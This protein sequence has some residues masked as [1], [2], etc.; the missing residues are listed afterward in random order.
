MRLQEKQ[1]YDQFVSDLEAEARAEV[2]RTRFKETSHS[3]ERN[4]NHETRKSSISNNK[5]ELND[6]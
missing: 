1:P 4:V 2:R 5:H 6:S 3:N